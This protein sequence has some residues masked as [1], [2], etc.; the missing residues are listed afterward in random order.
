MR[1][2]RVCRLLF[3]LCMKPQC[4]NVNSA[5]DSHW[6]QA[7]KHKNRYNRWYKQKITHIH[8]HL[9]ARAAISSGHS[10]LLSYCIMSY[11][12]CPLCDW[13]QM[14]DEMSFFFHSVVKCSRFNHWFTAIQM[15]FFFCFVHFFLWHCCYLLLFPQYKQ[16][17][18]TETC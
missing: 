13:Y 12:T 11:P 18:Y 8:T 6:S 3:Q 10:T 14:S 9:F 1:V 17:K 15:S 5:F 4:K 2:K 7:L 16:R